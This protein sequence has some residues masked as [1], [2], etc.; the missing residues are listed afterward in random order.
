MEKKEHQ[1]GFRGFKRSDLEV[2]FDLVSNP[3]HYSPRVSQGFEIQ[4]L[5]SLSYEKNSDENTPSSPSFM[6][7]NTD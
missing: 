3:S 2:N 6:T 7:E 5:S 4:K 1:A